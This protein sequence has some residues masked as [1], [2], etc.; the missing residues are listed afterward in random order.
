LRLAAGAESDFYDNAVN[1]QLTGVLV[2][3][4]TQIGSQRLSELFR[5]ANT[6]HHDKLPVWFLM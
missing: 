4:R 2:I 5:G 1:R 3:T 6:S